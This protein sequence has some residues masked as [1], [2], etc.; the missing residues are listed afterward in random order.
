MKRGRVSQTALKVAHNLVTLSA[1]DD[2]SQRL[3]PGLPEITERLL[4]ASDQPGYG[5]RMMRVSKGPWMIRAYGLQEWL[6]P[7]QFEGF[8]HRKIFV[9][10][11]VA[12]AIERGVTQVLVIGAGFDTL[13]LR[14]APRHP[15]VCF[16]ELDH[17]ATSSAKARGIALEDAPQN[18]LQI[19]ADLGERSLTRVL[20][21]DG[22]W[23]FSAPSVIVA[24]GLLQYLTDDD[25]RALLV[26]AASC[27][28]P[29]SRLVF[30]HAVPGYGRW[31]SFLT[32]LIAEPWLS[33]VRSEDLSAYVEETG[34]TILSD[35]D[36]D[37][38][39][40]AERYAVAERL[41]APVARVRLDPEAP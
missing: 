11:E 25:V 24:E 35:V 7:G 23:D 21:E 3:P 39:H 28:P 1:K 32:A 27:T 18:L 17:P 19:A 10:A 22:R 41:R 13:C 31:V 40:G 4:Q 36:T 12:A 14:L 8:G 5:P 9:N 29:G 33:A 26:E 30:T 34:W 37:E 15:D 6:L 20:Q 2:W 16:I 38:A